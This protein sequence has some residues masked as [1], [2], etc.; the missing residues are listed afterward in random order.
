MAGGPE[1]LPVTVRRL[2]QC[3]EHRQVR[4][5][6]PGDIPARPSR[7]DALVCQRG[8]GRVD[9]PPPRCHFGGGGEQGRRRL[10]HHRV[11]HDRRHPVDID[12]VDEPVPVQP[13]QRAVHRRLAHRT[14]DDPVEQ[15]GPDEQ[16][17]N[18]GVGAQ[19]QRPEY[20][21]GQRQAFVGELVERQLPRVADEAAGDVGVLD[22]RQL[23]EHR[24]L[25]ASSAVA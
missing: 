19:R 18:R 8:Q 20:R 7:G 21:P 1:R 15:R 25:R 11:Q 24:G 6:G 3:G 10:A 4:G 14:V 22:V 23:G 17:G 2:V 9:P 13:G 5:D 16:S 12:G